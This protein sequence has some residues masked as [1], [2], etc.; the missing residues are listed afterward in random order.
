MRGSM[1]T[2]TKPLTLKSKDFDSEEQEW[3]FKRGD[4][5]GEVSHKEKN[6]YCI[7]TYIYGI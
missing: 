2:M 4:L 3:A 7:L 5:K 1:E 6:K